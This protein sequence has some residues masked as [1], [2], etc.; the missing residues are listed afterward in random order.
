[1]VVEPVDDFHAG[2]VGALPVGEVGLP[3]LVGLVGF[4]PPIGALGRFLGSAV[5]SPA[6]TKIRRIVEVD[7]AGSC[8]CSR[9]Q[10]IVCGP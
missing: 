1:M 4:E 7:G 6:A 3:A 10:P 5:I 8:S 2:A 9:C